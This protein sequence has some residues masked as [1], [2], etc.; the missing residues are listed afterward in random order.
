MISARSNTRGGYSTNTCLIV[1][2]SEFDS[3]RLGRVVRRSFGDMPIQVAT[4]LKSARIALEKGGISLILLD[5][6]LPD[7]WGAEFA[8]EVTERPNMSHIP[9]IIVSDWPSPFMWQKAKAAGVSKVVSKREF[10]S[11]HLTAALKSPPRQHLN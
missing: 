10:N 4:D 9:I 3:E 6:N 11:G 2:D 1:E 8:I 5:N 7:G